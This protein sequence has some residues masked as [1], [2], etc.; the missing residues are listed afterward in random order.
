MSTKRNCARL[1]AETHRERVNP[2][3]RVLVVSICVASCKH[4]PAPEANRAAG[5]LASVNTLIERAEVSHR[6]GGS[7]M[8]MDLL[9]AHR[10]G[11]DARAQELELE[12]TFADAECDHEHAAALVGIRSGG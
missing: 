3:L 11:W 2:Y 10:A 4:A 5:G 7:F 12:R 6:A 8:V 9:D 1:C